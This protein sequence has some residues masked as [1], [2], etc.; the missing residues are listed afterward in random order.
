MKAKV[1]KCTAIEIDFSLHVAGIKV[2]LEKDT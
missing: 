1:K 2:W